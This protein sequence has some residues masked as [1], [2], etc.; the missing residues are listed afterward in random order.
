MWREC[1]YTRRNHNPRP[2]GTVRAG[3][4]EATERDDANAKEAGA[5]TPHKKNRKHR[6]HKSK[7]KKRRRKGDKESSS[8]SGGESEVEPLSSQKPVR[9]T[10]AR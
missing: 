10:R 8:E 7:K 1:L 9:H 4:G 5:E 2:A 6:K 3:E